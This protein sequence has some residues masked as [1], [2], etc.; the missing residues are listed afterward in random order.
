MFALSMVTAGN[1]F[2]VTAHPHQPGSLL[3]QACRIGYQS[4]FAI[5]DSADLTEEAY[6]TKSAPI[7]ATST[8]DELVVFESAQALPIFV[9]YVK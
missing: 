1:A 4:H 8:P 9:F 5:V 3:G 2:P 7:N 6:P